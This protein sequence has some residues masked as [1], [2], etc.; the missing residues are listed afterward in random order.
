MSTGGLRAWT[1]PVLCVT[2]LFSSVPGALEGQPSSRRD[3]VTRAV[4]LRRGEPLRI[5]LHD[6]GLVTG[7]N[8]G[9]VDG[10][11]VLTGDGRRVL[12]NPSEVETMWAA[13]SDAAEGLFV[14]ALLGYSL[15]RLG[16]ALSGGRR[17]ATD[18][19]VEAGTTVLFGAF[20]TLFGAGQKW[21]EVYIRPR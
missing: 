4:L 13:H 17:G 15:A 9:M 2:L 8:A 21:K 18:V 16:G 12:L 3:P 19:L 14:G 10:Q 1:T 5:E 20:G 11:I 6:G 7:T